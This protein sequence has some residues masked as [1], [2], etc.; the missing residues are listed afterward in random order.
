MINQQFRNIYKT[1]LLLDAGHSS[2]TVASKL[3]IHPFVAK[4]AGTFARVFSNR[5]L[6]EIIDILEEVDIMMKSSGMPPLILIEKA[7]FQIGE[8]PK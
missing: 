8:V 6:G 1:K 5:Q 3:E 4:K 7:L 2:A